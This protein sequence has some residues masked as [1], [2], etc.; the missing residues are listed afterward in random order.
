MPTS[1]PI[2]KNTKLEKYTSKL[3]YILIDLNRVSDEDIISKTHQDLCTQWA[4][5][6]MK[7]IFD[8]IKGFI[9]VLELIADYIKSQEHI[10]KSH[11]IFLTLDYIVS[12]K[13]NPEEVESILKELTGGDKKVMTLT[14]KWIMEGLQKGLQEGLQKGKQEGL[15]EGSLKTKKDAIKSAILIKFGVLPK[16]LEEKI[17]STDDIQILDE[18]FKKV[19]TLTEKWKMEGLQE[20]LQKGKQEGLQ[21]GLVKAKRDYVKSS[22]LIKFGVLP[23]ELEEKIETTDDIQTL[24]EMFKKVILAGKIEDIL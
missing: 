24:D 4:M 12:V 5:L 3:N 17:E 8:S 16:E 19:M 22:I 18:I 11:C 9:K 1:L 14:E 6:V 10:E 23:K 15:Q 21:E 2:V 20:G 7:H 13:D